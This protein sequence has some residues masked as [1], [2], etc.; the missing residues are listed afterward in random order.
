MKCLE[1]RQRKDGLKRRRYRL[2]DGRTMTTMEVPTTVLSRFSKA[3]LG[4]ALAAWQRG[5]ERRTRVARMRRLIAQGVK[6]A[7]VAAELGVTEQTVREQRKRMR[8]N[9]PP[10]RA[11]LP[12]NGDRKGST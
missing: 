11:V 4:A 6:P 3:A 9:P 5:E 7:A 10:Q 2:E 8:E 1:T 12:H